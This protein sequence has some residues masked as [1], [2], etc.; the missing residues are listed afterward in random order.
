[1]TRPSSQLPSIQ[2][3]TAGSRPSVEVVGAKCVT[4]I[5]T[6]A[7][8]LVSAASSRAASRS[9]RSASAG[10]PGATTS[11]PSTGQNPPPLPPT[12]ANPIRCTPVDH[13][14][15]SVEDG[16]T[17]EFEGALERAHPHATAVVIA[18]DGDD[19]QLGQAE[20]FGRQFDLDDPATVGDVTG[21]HEDV[22]AVVNRPDLAHQRG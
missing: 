7:A 14:I 6:S 2:Y 16:D 10:R 9:A 22:G 20:E 18:E 21:D 11:G 8:R 19:R 12:P 3:L 17:G 13:Q 5:R 1:M 15:R 4:A